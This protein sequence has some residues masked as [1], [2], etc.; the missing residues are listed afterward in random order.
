[1]PLSPICIFFFFQAE[2]GLQVPLCSVGSE[3]VIKS[4]Q[5]TQVAPKI[6]SSAPARLTRLLKS[7]RVEKSDSYCD[8]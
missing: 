4:K 2:A 6:P 5:K 1:R 8:K 3:N 7:E